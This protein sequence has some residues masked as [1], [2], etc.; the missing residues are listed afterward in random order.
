MADLRFRIRTQ[1]RSK[2]CR[3]IGIDDDLVGRKDLNIRR[4]DDLKIVI[5]VG[6]RVAGQAAIPD[7]PAHD[8]DV[9]A[10]GRRRIGRF[11]RSIAALARRGEGIRTVA[12]LRHRRIVGGLCQAGGNAGFQRDVLIVALG[13]VVA[14]AGNT[15]DRQRV[16]S[17]VGIE[18][19]RLE[20]GNVAAIEGLQQIRGLVRLATVGGIDVMQRSM[21]D[22]CNHHVVIGLG[23]PDRN[24]RRKRDAAGIVGGVVDD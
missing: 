13:E 5:G 16:D 18:N 17:N 22:A 20:N 11:A 10:I 19:V 23:Q 7:R 12:D 2:G 4:V 21:A 9:T 1:R 3:R 6:I 8:G 14:I 24:R 15:V